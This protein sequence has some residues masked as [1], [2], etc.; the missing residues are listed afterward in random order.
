MYPEEFSFRFTIEGVH[1]FR[2]QRLKELRR[3][4]ELIPCQTYRT[5]RFS[6]RWD[7]TDFGN[8]DVPFAQNNGLPFGKSLKIAGEMSFCFM[9]DNFDHDLL[10]A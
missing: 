7:G 4:L 9:N 2:W 5:L 10:S 3:N 6:I 1:Y 8:G